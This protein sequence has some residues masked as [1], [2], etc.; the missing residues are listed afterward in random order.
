[1]ALEDDLK[2]Q[3]YNKEEAY[4]HALNKALIEKKK[5]GKQSQ[6][7]CPQCGAVLET[8]EAFGLR[9]M[10]CRECLGT[11]LEKEALE[12]LL[13]AK[14]PQQFLSALLRPPEDP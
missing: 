11:F 3:G 8:M 5:K 7:K 2:K 13:E 6:G 4:F 14:D 12:S 1:M 9:A 10:C